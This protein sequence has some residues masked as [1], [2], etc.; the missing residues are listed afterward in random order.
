MQYCIVIAADAAAAAAAVAVAFAVAVA[1]AVAVVVAA[2]DHRRQC[3]AASQ[4]AG[5][6]SRGSQQ[7]PFAKRLSAGRSHR[8]RR[9]LAS[10]AGS[11]WPLKCAMN[12]LTEVGSRVFTCARG[13]KSIVLPRLDFAKLA[14]GDTAFAPEFIAEHMQEGLY[15]FF[16]KACNRVYRMQSTQDYRHGSLTPD[17]LAKSGLELPLPTAPTFTASPMQTLDQRTRGGKLS[18]PIRLLSWNADCLGTQQWS[19]SKTWLHTSA[20]RTCGVLALQ[21]KHW[22]ETAEFVVEGWQML[23][24]QQL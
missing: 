2:T 16:G 12:A 5:A 14:D 8:V 4:A 17:Y 22:N 18:K 15:D 6:N 20:Q 9:G 19:E 24:M 13:E 11:Q 3:C 23:A 7:A 21:E 10:A 1:V